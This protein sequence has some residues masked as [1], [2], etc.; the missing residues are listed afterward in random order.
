M[1]RGG[2][3]AFGICLLILFH[4][5]IT[6]GTHKFRVKM[7][8]TVLKVWGEI[9]RYK[10][11]SRKED[12][13]WNTKCSIRWR[14]AFRACLMLLVID[15][16]GN[17]IHVC[18]FIFLQILLAMIKKSRRN[19]LSRFPSTPTNECNEIRENKMQNENDRQWNL[20]CVKAE[21][22]NE[23]KRQTEKL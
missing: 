3:V 4:Q 21:W 13:W 5:W 15:L 19:V 20:S 9:R 12:E 17:C 18:L 23:A 1:F 7:K 8:E 22:S 16:T 14:I 6:K 2:M 11:L 10:W